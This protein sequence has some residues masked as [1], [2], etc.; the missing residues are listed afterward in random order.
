MLILDFGHPR[1]M[2]SGFF[3]SPWLWD[4][5]EVKTV[6]F[7]DGFDDESTIEISSPSA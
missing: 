1:A 2:A 6:D 5:I 3:E 4:G 7:E